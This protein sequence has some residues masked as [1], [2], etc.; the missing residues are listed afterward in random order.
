VELVSFPQR[1]QTSVP[2]VQV[3]HHKGM[4]VMILVD[5][6]TATSYFLLINIPE[7]FCGYFLENSCGLHANSQRGIQMK[8]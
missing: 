2:N 6:A 5:V 3:Q 7:H 1:V 4:K 8:I